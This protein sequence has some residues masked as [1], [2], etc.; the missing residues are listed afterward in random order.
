MVCG[1]VLLIAALSL[2]VHNQNEANQA[3]ISAEQI[4]TQVQDAV[5]TK[6]DVPV[7]APRPGGNDT[8]M[9]VVEIDGYGYIGTLTIPKLGLTLPVMDTLSDAQLKLAPCRYTGSVGG[10]DMV[11]GA[12]NYRYHFGMLRQLRPGDEIRFTDMTGAV[13]AYEAAEITELSPT[14]VEEM[15]AGAYDL[16]LFTCTY[17]GRSRITVR[18]LR[19]EKKA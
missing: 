10:G 11:I 18:C 14:D 6:Q 16:T 1:A 13:F 9:K 19:T 3:K 5:G 12:H 2:F 4:L 17:G 8:E 15:T 7:S